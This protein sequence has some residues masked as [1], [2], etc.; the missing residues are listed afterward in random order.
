MSNRMNNDLK[1]LRRALG[2]KSIQVFAE[3]YFGHYLKKKM[4]VMHKELY[5][6]LI[7]LQD[8][9]GQR[10]A[11]AAP[12]DSAKSSIVSLIYA[13]WCI[14]YS[15]ENY[16]LLLSD[17]NKQAADNLSHIK[18]ELEN[19][20]K[21]LEDFPDICEI[22]QKP[23]PERWTKDEIITRNGIK[24]TALGSGQKIRGRR[25][26][27]ERP[28]LI[29][30]DDIENEEGILY[31]E[32][33]QKLFEWFTKA[34]LKAGSART[35]FIIV[36]TILH[37]DSLLAKLLRDNE[38]P[39]WY[40][41]IYKSVISWSKHPELWQR[42]SNIFNF[43]D[44]YQDKSGKEAANAFYNDNQ[45]AMLEGAAVLW[46]EQ[47]DYLS[48][49][50]MREQEGEWS[51]DSEKQNEPVNS[52]DCIFNP[53]EFYYWDTKFASADELLR[54]LGS[55]I[56]IY[57]A[58]DPS[59]GKSGRNGDFSAVITVVRHKETGIIYVL[60][61]DIAKRKPDKLVSDILE[62]CRIRN[63]TKFMFESN[64][65]QIVLVDEIV[66]LGAQKGIYPKIEAL[67]N[68][69]DKLSRIESMQ[70]LIKSGVIQFSR[71]H[72]ELLIQLKYF[73]KGPHDDGPDA[74][75]M[76]VRT[77]QS[78]AGTHKVTFLDLNSDEDDGD[79]NRER[80]IQDPN[81]REYG[82]QYDKYHCDEDD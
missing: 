40:K 37:Y 23:S 17:T 49:M 77:C 78:K 41:K 65:F 19:N 38:M 30:L 29:I 18:Y 5:Q 73:P 79:F 34:V 33:R 27:E 55:D 80:P 58:C 6:L 2:E 11:V 16:I 13:L 22:G 69:S 15:K 36:G 66:R 62:Y 31:A 75:E 32:S 72:T 76:A 68:T 60:D 67:N 61:A 82:S 50:E 53:E 70:A 1:N 54:A 45:E 7:A 42:W 43:R 51:F 8:K 21:L 47:E 71:K 44:T 57:G 3:I 52:T 63:Y 4:C 9:R 46:P 10:I 81:E 48:L 20:E 39:G 24:I 25:N 12:R 28:S 14:C 26:K 35:N 56:E 64:Q 59:L 74:L